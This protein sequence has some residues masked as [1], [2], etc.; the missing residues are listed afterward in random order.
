M[1]HAKIQLV[2]TISVHLDNYVTLVL[3]ISTL[4]TIILVFT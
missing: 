4:D 3:T 2:L 1:L